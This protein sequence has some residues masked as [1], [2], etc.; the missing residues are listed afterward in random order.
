M[1]L[2]CFDCETT[3][4]LAVSAADIK[5]KPHM[6]DLYAIKLTDD[7]VRFNTF[8]VRCKPPIPIPLDA[9]KV[10]GITDHD[11]VECHSFAGVYP[12]IAEFFLGSRVLV[13]HNLLYDKMVL[14]YELMRI[15]KNL[16]FPWATGGICTAEVSSQ[17][18]GYRMNLT[19][20]HISLFGEGFAGAHSASSDCEITLK[21]FVEMK[22]REM[23]TALW[24]NGQ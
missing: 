11:V 20:L 17:Y 10:H 8:H 18:H 4:L 16:N 15:G 3:G 5:H 24:V 1:S 12:A 13:G 6:I 21:C 19:D 9:T 14:Y 2:I 22:R 23:V 7:L